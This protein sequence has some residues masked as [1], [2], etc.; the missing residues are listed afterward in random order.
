M[1]ERAPVRPLGEALGSARAARDRLR[2]R[3]LA[4]RAELNSCEVHK[5]GRN[6][7]PSHQTAVVQLLAAVAVTGGLLLLFGGLLGALRH[8]LI[9]AGLALQAAG[10]A[11]LGSSGVVVLLDG[12]PLGAHFHSSLSPALGVDR[13]SAFFFLLLAGAALP[14]LIFARGYLTALRERAAARLITALT[15][16]F[17]AALFGV[18]AARDLVSFLTF[19]E[20]MTLLPAAA[21][22]AARR[23]AVVRS[24]VYVYLALTHLGGAGVWIALLVLAQHGAIGNP[25]ALAAAGT[26]TQA[27]VAAAALIGFGT[28]AGLIP[29]H[30]WLPRAHPVAPAHLSA[31]MSAAMTKVALY[32]LIR[33]LFFWLGER[34]LWVAL[35]LLGLGL[36]STFGGA[37]WAVAQHELKRVLAYSTI[38]NV[39]VVAIALAAALIYRHD[40]E[41]VWASIA[42]GAALLHAL[43]HALAKSGLFLGA[44]AIERA[45]G[46]LELDRLG[47][48]AARMRWAGGGMLVGSAAIAGLPPLGLFASEWL[49]LQAL[50]HLAFTHRAGIALAAAVSVAG[51]GASV[52]LAALGFSR[53]VGLTLLGR[54]RSARGAAATDPAL[55]MR[56]GIVLSAAGCLILGLLAGELLPLL[57]RVTPLGAA[58][59]RRVTLQ[60]PGSGLL[61]APGLTVAL[62]LLPACIWWLSGAGRRAAAPAPTWACGQP[63][64]GELEWTSAGFTK[65]IRIVLE[66]LLRPR[67][68]LRTVVENGVVQELTY[69]SETPS[70]VDRALYEPAIRAGL[71]AAAV[72][73]RLQSGNVRTYAAY[74]LVALIVAMA[75]TAGGVLS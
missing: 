46:T 29:L 75:L 44:G 56:V 34:S 68:G 2:N 22:L 15:A 36:A 32:G 58:L 31:L 19:W 71:R 25:A 9:G 11:L 30:S 74:L 45:V 43:N 61:P 49:A 52:G 24:A 14:A 12:R 3:A 13:L 1:T 67:R 62:V 33:V 20:L 5:I 50:I 63:L 10:T 28:K 42:F 35:V 41:R 21:M 54:P 47:G 55:S 53:V 59:P 65:P 39:G 27:G 6:A 57:A 8:A 38:E 69:T 60:V 48:L 4:G 7:C 66:G 51:L 16:G 40:G 37:L 17:L 26:A 72:T 18:L 73:R 23:D 64:S 70:L